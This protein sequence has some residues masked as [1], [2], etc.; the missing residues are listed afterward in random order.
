MV[1]WRQVEI[2]FYRG[3]GRHR[4]RGFGA[5]AQVIGRTA[6]PFLRKY[7]VPA[8]KRLGA[9]LLEYAVPETAAVVNVRKKIK[10]PAKS[11]GG[12]FLRK[13]L[14][15][16]NRKNPASKVIL[17]K[18]ANKP[19]S[20][21]ESF[22][23][24]FSL[25]MSNSFRYQPFVAFSENLGGEVPVVDNV[26]FSHEHEKYP[27][28]SLHENCKQFEFQTNRNYSFDLRQTNL[29]LK[30][31]FVMGPSY[32]TCNTKQLRKVHEEDANLD[33][34]TEEEQ[35]VPVPLVTHV[36]SIMHSIFSIVEVYINNQQKYNS[37]GL[38][39]KNFFLF[40][41]FQGSHLW[42]QGIFMLRGFGLWRKSSWNYG[43]TLVWTLFHRE[44][45]NAC[46]TR[47]LHVGW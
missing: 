22:Y 4:A 44:N 35:E 45:E 10:P 9:D 2:P 14:S 5:I 12:Q 33:V 28:T 25:F 37:N 17:A 3:V 21:E 13:Q 47:W 8:A 1:V 24:H 36:K 7:I 29:A 16:L 40:E 20:R 15:I 18:S 30:L 42:R 32:E 38:Y 27:T 43:R 11:V 46:Q 34:E 41:Q 19:F 23:N 39:E 6:I 26:L 31:K